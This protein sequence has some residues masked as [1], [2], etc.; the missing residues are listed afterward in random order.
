MEKYLEILKTCPLFQKINTENLLKMLS[1]MGAR[2]QAFDKKYTI[3]MQGNPAKYIGVVLSGTVQMVH[4]D[5]SG[6]R[7]VLGNIEAGEIF[8]EA[9]ACAE[10]PVLPITVVANEPCEILLIENQHMLHTCSNHCQFHQQI[11]YNL[12]KDLAQKVL[13][14]HRKLEILSKRSTREKLLTYLMMQAEKEGALCFEIPFD[15]QELA[16]YL[17][18]D[19]SGLSAEIGKLQ[20]EGVLKS[21]KREFELL[22][23]VRRFVP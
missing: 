18:V 4:M 9:F 10:L 6:N 7:H 23:I 15:R 14:F 11:I 1:C 19:R 2:V 17:Q 22:S 13:F 20:K 8:A 16:D 3:F 5:Y 21:R 12:M